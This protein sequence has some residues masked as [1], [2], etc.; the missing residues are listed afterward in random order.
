MREMPMFVL[1]GPSASGK[2]TVAQMLVEQLGMKRAVTTTTRKRRRWEP[3]DAY[4]FVSKESFRVDDMV[5]S[6]E[7]AGNYYGLS[8]AEADASNLVIL[9]PKGAM[10]L[11]SY[12]GARRCYVV[13]IP[14]SRRAQAERMVMRGDSAKVINERIAFDAIAFQNFERICDTVCSADTVEELCAIIKEYIGEHTLT[15]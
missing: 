5:E 8:K 4:H 12:C 15:Q 2:S 9:E 11:R 3:V 6:Q 1:V 7:Y 10:A 14:V 13:G